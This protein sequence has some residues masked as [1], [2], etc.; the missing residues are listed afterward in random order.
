MLTDHFQFFVSLW[1]ELQARAAKRT[2]D[3]TSNMTYDDV[4]GRTSS[5]VGVEEDGGLFDETIS[6]YGMRRKGAQ[7]LLVRALDTAHSK[8]LRTYVTRVQWTTIGDSALL[9][10]FRKFSTD[11]MRR[12]TC[13]AEDPSQLTISPEL[14]QPLHILRGNFE[15]L[16]KAISTACYRRIWREALGKVQD[17][18]W[19]D[20][21][22][23]QTF[24]TFGA[25]QFARD[26]AAVFALVDR[27]IPHGSAAMHT[28]SEGLRLLNLPTEPERPKDGDSASMALKEASDR[29]FTDNDE[30]R[31]VLEELQLQAL[32]PA[33]AR[34]ILQRRVENSE[35]VGW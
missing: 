5:S 31:K 25:A 13:D 34:L 26:V 18:L 7:D 30:A 17:Q 24:S 11:N 20:V 15:F 16:A 22:I 33:N 4:K 12:L 14:D 35:N 23:R 9:G 29:V 2:S 8:A 10:K 6:A 27:F 3:F 32:T 1:D 19:H 28:L 21:L